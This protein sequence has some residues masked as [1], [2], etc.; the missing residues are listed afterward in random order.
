MLDGILLPLDASILDVSGKLQSIDQDG[1]LVYEE[2]AIPSSNMLT[3]CRSKTDAQL[4]ETLERI[5]NEYPN[6]L[7]DMT[8]EALATRPDYEAPQ[9]VEPVE[10]VPDR[11]QMMSWEAM[12]KLRSDIYLQLK[13][14][15][16]IFD[17]LLADD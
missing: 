6:G 17:K 9:A 3:E 4:T 14:A 5:W 16:S 10:E 15:Y 7:L 2:Y 12:E 13:F 1:K 11:N 8:E